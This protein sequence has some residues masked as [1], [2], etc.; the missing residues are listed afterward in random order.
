MATMI[1]LSLVAAL[2]AGGGMIL[3]PLLAALPTAASMSHTGK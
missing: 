1:R 3:T 2:L